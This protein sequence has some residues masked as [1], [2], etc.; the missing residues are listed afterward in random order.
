VRAA[1]A[2]VESENV[3]AGIVYR[4]DAA[5]SKRVRVAF[6]FP[7]ERGPKIVYALAPIA[8]SRNAG[9][10][11]LVRYLVSP[12]AIQVYERHGFLVLIGR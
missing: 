11:D 10:R 6:E 1:L 2:A 3:D 5:I 4:S 12:D 7:P 9:T 8:A